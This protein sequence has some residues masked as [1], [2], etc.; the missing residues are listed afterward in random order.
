M[1]DVLIEKS[2]SPKRASAI[3]SAFRNLIERKWIPDKTS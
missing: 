3:R 2:F 1:V